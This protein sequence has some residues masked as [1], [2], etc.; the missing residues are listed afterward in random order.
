MEG[1]AQRILRGEAPE[2]L[3]NA[4]VVAV[5]PS[6]L[7]AG[8]VYRGEFDERMK[9]LLAEASAGG[10]ILFIDEVHSIIGA[11]GPA[12]TGDMASLLK[13]ALARGELSCIA[14]TTDEEYRRFIEPDGALERRFQP[15]RVQELTAAQTLE[16]LKA[17]RDELS[18]LRGVE[19]DDSVLEW[20]VEFADQFLRN[21]YF[22]DKAVDL[23]EQCVASAVAHGEKTL[24]RAGAE[25][26]AQRMIGMPI[27]AET[28]LD[29]LKDRLHSRGLLTQED[30]AILLHRMEV[31]LRGLDVRPARPNCIALLVNGAAKGGAALAETIAETLFGDSH[32][33]VTIDFAPFTE[34]FHASA[35][36]GASP[37]YIGYGDAIPLHRVAQMPW[38]VLLCENIH[39]CHPQVREILQDALETGVITDGCGRRIYLS[40]TVVLI[41]AAIAVSAGRTAGFRSA[42]PVSRE[43]ACEA[44]ERELGEAFVDTVDLVCSELASDAAGSPEG[45]L[46]DLA[47]RY[48]K[49]GIQIEWDDSLIAWM[50]RSAHGH[51]HNGERL[52]D[53][54]LIPLLIPYLP[55]AEGAGSRQLMIR[56]E[57]GK[58]SVEEKG[59]D[60]KGEG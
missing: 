30:D 19:V 27:H 34:P 5:Q 49:Q 16:V 22:P 41:T 54:S 9:N 26:V 36:L 37:N 55:A 7:A 47:H 51:G 42:G 58:L 39:A 59:L 4:R 45:L 15:I 50:T 29:Q 28:R 2:A 33:V 60:E 8:A 56:S 57:E 53:E 32:R 52:L 31:T 21:R 18:E 24:H 46:T 10:V 13:P 38:C 25:R 6:S 35:L 14:A 44:A 48:R 43:S 40:D 1:L 17:A 3:R 11:G 23:L 20:L 12:G